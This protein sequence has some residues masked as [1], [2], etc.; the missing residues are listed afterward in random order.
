VAK[1]IDVYPSDVLGTMGGYQMLLTGDILRGKFRNSLS[2]PEPMV[3]NRV[4]HL[5]FELG[6]K[7]HTFHTG[8]R[9]MVQIQSS[10][11]PMFDRNPQTFVDIY[12]A[13]ESDYQ[14]AT[15]KIYRSP[16]NSSRIQ[17]TVRKKA[18]P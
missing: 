10:W 14:E 9:I 11:F 8:H 3:P 6:D 13:R 17:L 5:E 12:H 15:Q 4:S 1:L 16:A 18:V 7:N 2:N